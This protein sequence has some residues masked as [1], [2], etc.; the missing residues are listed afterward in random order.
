MEI[1]EFKTKGERIEFLIKNKSSLMA[2]KKADLKRADAISFNSAVILP[3]VNKAIGES[4]TELTVTSVINTTNLMDSHDD[5]HFPGLW[6]KSLQENKY[7]ML[8]QEH[9][10]SFE[11]IIA[12]E[13]EVKAYTKAMTWKQLGINLPGDTEALVF[14]S[15]V[16]M[17]RNPYMFEQYRKGYVKQHS[18][19]MRYV[20]LFL[21][22]DDD[23]YPEENELWNK[24]ID[25]IANRERAEKKGYFW[26]V[27]EAGVIEGSAVPLGSNYATPTLSV[28]NIPAPGNTTQEQPVTPSA[29][30]L[31][32]IIENSFKT[33][34]IN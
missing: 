8:L 34:K 10:L 30:T 4:K 21:A 1:P 11:S 27:P 14:E 7:I 3:G 18:V 33:I 17:E 16:K 2:T 20:R 32:K 5:V 23:N 6:D 13:A 22:V 29:D 15:V 9:K 12:D 31:R 19:G 25:Q 26:G 28:K 24:Y